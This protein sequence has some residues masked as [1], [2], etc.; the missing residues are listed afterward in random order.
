MASRG[1]DGGCSGGG[2]HVCSHGSSGGG[3]GAGGVGL[4]VAIALGVA[5]TWCTP[6][7]E[8]GANSHLAVCC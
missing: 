5:C 4:C 2:L 8:K 3:G 1:L 7:S 6:T